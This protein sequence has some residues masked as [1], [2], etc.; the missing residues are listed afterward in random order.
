MFVVPLRFAVGPIYGSVLY[1]LFGQAVPFLALAA[2]VFFAIGK[3]VKGRAFMSL[4][5]IFIMADSAQAGFHE[6]AFAFPESQQ[7]H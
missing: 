2:V 7:N 4:H 5:G 3:H 6:I 1:E